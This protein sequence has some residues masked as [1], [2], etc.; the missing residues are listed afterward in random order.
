MQTVSSFWNINNSHTIYVA[1]FGTIIN[2]LSVLLVKKNIFLL[3]LYII[4]IA[5]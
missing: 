2:F 4:F 5:T 3:L 1:G